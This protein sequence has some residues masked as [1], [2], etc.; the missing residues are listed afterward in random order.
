MLASMFIL[1]IIVSIGIGL[2]G[3]DWLL[4]ASDR[5]AGV[6]ARRPWLKG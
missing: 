2:F 5:L 6:Q 1:S 3:A 4:T